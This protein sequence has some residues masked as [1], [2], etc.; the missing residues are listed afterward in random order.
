MTEFDLRKATEELAKTHE[1]HQKYIEKHEIIAK[2]LTEANKKLEERNAL[3]K[4]EMEKMQKAIDAA[5]DKIKTILNRYEASRMYETEDGLAELNYNK[6]QG[7]DSYAAKKIAQAILKD[8]YAKEVGKNF[9]DFLRNP[10]DPSLKAKA[11]QKQEEIKDSAT[12]QEDSM[13]KKTLNTM[14]ESGNLLVPPQVEMKVHK[15]LRET[16]PIRSIATVK[17]IG[18]PEYVTTV[19]NNIPEATFDE[20]PEVDKYKATTEQ[21]YSTIKIPA[22]VLTAR[23]ELTLNIIEDAWLDVESE[24]LSRLAYA[25]E[26]AENKAFIQ[27]KGGPGTFRG[28]VGFY[29]AEGKANPSFDEPQKMPLISKTAASLNAKDGRPLIDTF[30]EMEVTPVS[31][32]KRRGA[33]WIMHKMLKH[34]IRIIKDANGQF[35]L[36]RGFGF[37]SPAGLE[38]I[39]DGM[40]GTILGYGVLECDDMDSTVAA[41]N[42]PV[43]FGHWKNYCIVD[44]IGLTV[45]IDPYTSDRASI[46]YKCRKRVGAG[47]KL[48]QGNVLLKNT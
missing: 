37:G 15:Q 13:I 11:L 10:H 21:S 34:K 45:L 42:Y 14:T 12:S 27:G 38:K 39:K 30:S 16:S 3:Q 46:I 18:A 44:R 4:S 7:I 24:L 17:M 22:V 43:G 5:E 25:F 47:F 41:G 35:L 8:P 9:E 48:C 2:N 26:L 19:E 6:D 31:G 20:D 33:N 40:S 28:I 36:S 29:G 23:P 1:E 32:W